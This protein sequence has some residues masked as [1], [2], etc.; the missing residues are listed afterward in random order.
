MVTDTLW[1]LLIRIKNA[2]RVK[3]DK[4]KVIYSKL[5][6][7]LLKILKKNN[8][9]ENYEIVEEWNNKKTIS[10]QLKKIE[11]VPDFK[12]ISKP[13]R[14]IYVRWK[15]IKKS[16]NGMWIYI[17]STSRWLMTGYEAWSLKIWGELLCE[18]Y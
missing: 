15:D 9:I 4:T 2:Y 5:N 14:R 18:V 12:R 13:W 16:K 17:I 6:E 1:D 10:V 11:Y 8:Y 7:S 3:L